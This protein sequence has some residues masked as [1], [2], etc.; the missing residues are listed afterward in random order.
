MIKGH[1]KGT[2]ANQMLFIFRKVGGVEWKIRRCSFSTTSP[3]PKEDQVGK[4]NRMTTRSET[5]SEV[6][7]LPGNRT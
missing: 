4:T 7:D 5:R 2:E 1:G 3:P 6:T